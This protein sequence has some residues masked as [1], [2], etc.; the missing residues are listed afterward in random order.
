[1]A[2]FSELEQMI[3]KFI[4][5]HKDPKGQRNLEKQNVGVIT[6]PDI[7]LYYKAA[8]IKAVRH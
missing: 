6:L 5:N 7:K 4:L 1:M 2:C 3:F 8:R